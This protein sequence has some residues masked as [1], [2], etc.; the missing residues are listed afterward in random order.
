MKTENLDFRENTSD[1]VLVN[2]VLGGLMTSEKALP[3]K[4]FYDKRGSELFDEICRLDEYYQ[5]RTELSILKKNLAEIVEV[6]GSR[7]QLVEYGSGSSVK[8]R[9]L[10]HALSDLVSYI[11]IDISREYLNEVVFSLREQFPKLSILPVYADYTRDLVLPAMIPGAISRRVFF[12]PGSTIGNLD[13]PEALALLAQTRRLAGPKGALLIGIDLQKSK[14][15]LEAAYNDSRGV[16][17]EFNKNLLVRLNSEMGANFTLSDFAHHAHYNE[18]CGRIEMHLVSRKPQ[19]V[20]VAGSEIFFREGETIHTE[21][22]YKYTREGFEK[23]AQTVGF[24]AERY[25]T[26]ENN[27]FGIYYLT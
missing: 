11:P 26:D 24:S 8:T 2:E 3:A 4:L 22:S 20:T 12:F 5:T 18:P 14:T 23:M 21:N 27:N 16:T 17:A 19:T 1:S 13:E 6:I 25:W 15:T 10:L 7:A 9:V